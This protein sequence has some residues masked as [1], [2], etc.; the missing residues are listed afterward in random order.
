MPL[1]YDD[2]ECPKCGRMGV[3]PN[4]GYDWVCP[5][6]DYEGSFVEDDD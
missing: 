1:D 5:N 6:C 4:G 3:F 2:I